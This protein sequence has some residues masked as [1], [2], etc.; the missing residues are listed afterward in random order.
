[1]QS[2]HNR[3]MHSTPIVIRFKNVALWSFKASRDQ[4]Y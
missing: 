3:P 1:M 4:F 2:R